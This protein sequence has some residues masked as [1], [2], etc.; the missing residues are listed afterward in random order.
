MIIDLIIDRKENE[1][2]IAEGHTHKILA[3]VNCRGI[4]YHGETIVKEGGID[5]TLIPLQYEP[6]NF[7]QHVMEYGDVGFGITAAMDG[8]TEEDVK[9]E[10]CKYIKDNEYNMELCEYINSVNWL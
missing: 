7:Y 2:L 5:C 4:L 8:G 1:Q 9:R 3:G 10:L 6:K